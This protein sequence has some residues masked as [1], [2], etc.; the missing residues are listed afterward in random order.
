MCYIIYFIRYNYNYISDY[1]LCVAC[2]NLY[3]IYM[4]I[5]TN[6]KFYI[7]CY[8]FD[9]LNMFTITHVTC[10]ILHSIYYTLK[11][12]CSFVLLYVIF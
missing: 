8:V 3:V 12:I 10:Y 1:K 6:V 5:Y 7:L 11:N 9:I 2:Y 4:Y